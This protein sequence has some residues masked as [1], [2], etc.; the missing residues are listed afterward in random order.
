M[1]SQATIGDSASSQY[2]YDGPSLQITGD[3]LDTWNDVQVQSGR[4][5][6]LG[7][8]VFF[9]LQSGGP[10]GA[11]LQE[12][13]SYQ[14]ASVYGSRTLQGLTSLQQ[15][16]DSDALAIAQNYLEWY[17]NPIARVTSLTLSS[18]GNAGANL[19]LMLGLGIMDRL[20]VQ[21]QG[22]TPSSQFSQ[23]SLIEQITHTIDM[24]QPTWTTQLRYPLT[25]SC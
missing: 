8:A 13:I 22:Q 23:D 1:T 18:Q 19:P 10:S 6:S 17:Q 21:Y 3:D 15:Q 5:G 24:A 25:R 9:V 20:T 7:N 12:A 11:Q 4:S 16:N 14:S 2:F